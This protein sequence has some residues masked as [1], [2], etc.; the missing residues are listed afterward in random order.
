[1][2]LIG[3]LN[4]PTKLRKVTSELNES[5]GKICIVVGI[6]E[7]DLDQ[8]LLLRGDAVVF[9]NG[10]GG[11]YDAPGPGFYSYPKLDRSE[12]GGSHR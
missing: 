12:K 2:G 6:V 1:M 7:V 10:S 8:P 4:P 5:S 9:Q 11:M 3:G